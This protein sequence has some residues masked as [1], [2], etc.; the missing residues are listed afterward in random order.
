M[1]ILRQ[2]DN[3]F[4]CSITYD[5]ANDKSSSNNDNSCTKLLYVVTPEKT[6]SLSRKKK[7]TRMIQSVWLPQGKDS[8]LWKYIAIWILQTF[9]FLFCLFVIIFWMFANNCTL[10]SMTISTALHLKEFTLENQACC[11]DGRNALRWIYTHE[12]LA[13][14]S[15]L[16]SSLIHHNTEIMFHTPPPCIYLK[17]GLQSWNDSRQNVWW[18]KYIYLIILLTPKNNITMW[19][20]L[21][22]SFWPS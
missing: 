22:A 13:R 9:D 18:T 11:G 2:G 14:N 4:Y 20:S 7:N 16:F 19:K 21:S 3:K 5:A 10:L 8:V 6:N 15:V 1:T 17:M 12:N